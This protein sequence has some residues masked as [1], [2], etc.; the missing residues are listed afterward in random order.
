M[1]AKT[2]AHKI[3]RNVYK[4]MTDSAREDVGEWC[5]GYSLLGVQGCVSL[6][7]SA[8]WFPRKLGIDLPQDPAILDIYLEYIYPK[9]FTSYYRDT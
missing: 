2:S 4:L 5:T 7:K 3:K 1:Q 9:D 6:W 8:F